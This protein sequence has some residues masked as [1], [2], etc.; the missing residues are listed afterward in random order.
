MSAINRLKKAT[1]RG[2]FRGVRMLS[3]QE[4]RLPLHF[5]SNHL[6][7]CSF[8]WKQYE[9]IPQQ[10]SIVHKAPQR[11]H[12]HTLHLADKL[13]TNRSF[14]QSTQPQFVDG[15]FEEQRQNYQAL[16]QLIT[17]IQSHLPPPS[18]H[19]HA[20]AHTQ[21]QQQHNAAKHFGLAEPLQLLITHLNQ[22]HQMDVTGNNQMDEYVM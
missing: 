16:Y 18:S 1:L 20:H 21:Q 5:P 8:V 4:P 9:A 2:S 22:M 7:A 10:R 13:L 6:C 3:H 12:I 19:K 11:A 14:A 17:G 15:R